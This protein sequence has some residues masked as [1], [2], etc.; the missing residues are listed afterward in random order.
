MKKETVY[1]VANC[2]ACIVLTGLAAYNPTGAKTGLL[3]YPEWVSPL[4][5]L[6]IILIFA[7]DKFKGTRHTMV[8]IGLVVL[9]GVLL[10]IPLPEATA[11]TLKW[12]YPLVAGLLI[13]IFVDL[14]YE[15][16]D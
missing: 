4:V 6:V 10:V 5:Y 16:N 2:I 12:W 7:I 15:D 1:L 8:N 14:D 3:E 11:S 13:H 9:S